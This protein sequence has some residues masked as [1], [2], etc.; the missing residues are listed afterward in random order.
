MLKKMIVAGLAIA[1]LVGCGGPPK[2]EIEKATLAKKKADEAMAEVYAA[3]SY[4]AATAAWNEGQ[5]LVKK[6]DNDK[7][8]AKYVEA[9]TAFDKSA[10]DAPAGKDAMKAEVEKSIT[11]FETAW[12]AG[13]KDMTKAGSKMKGDDKTAFE[14]MMADCEAGLAECKDMMS[15]DDIKGAK[16]KMASVMDNH[17][18]I[19]EK[20]A[21]KKM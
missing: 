8:K 7:A 6:G 5:E 13:K 4:S 2:A 18:A 11:D 9:A 21:P 12:T 16:D 14:K 20:M 10:A 15:K 17:K 19:T 1:V 3:E